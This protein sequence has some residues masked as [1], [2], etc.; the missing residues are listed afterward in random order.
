MDVNVQGSTEYA[1]YFY[2]QRKLLFSGP[3]NQE[4]NLVARKRILLYSISRETTRVGLER[5]TFWEH[6]VFH[7]MV[8]HSPWT[9]ESLL[10]EVIECGILS[11]QTVAQRRNTS[12]SKLIR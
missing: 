5:G 9:T 1:V 3:H 11:R 6:S 2:S 12:V 4:V 10:C 7:S 8:L